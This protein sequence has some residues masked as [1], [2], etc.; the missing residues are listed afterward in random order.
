MAKT[1]RCGGC[2]ACCKTHPVPE[3]NKPMGE[4]C[5][6]CD[7]GKGCHIYDTRPKGCR[8]FTCQW[9]TGHWGGDES[10]PDR[11][12]FV[13]DFVCLPN[14]GFTLILFEVESGALKTEAARTAMRRGITLRYSIMSVP[15][16]DTP[17]LKTRA[18]VQDDIVLPNGREVR[19]ERMVKGG[20]S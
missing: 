5:P 19:I 2:T 8:T 9:L 20:S 10:R 3:T 12:Q 16:D 15:L 14:V 1:M 6:S 11:V 7:I 17:I 4:W 18:K 13:I